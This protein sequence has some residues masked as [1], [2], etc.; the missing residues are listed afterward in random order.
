MKSPR[1]SRFRSFPQS[2]R[3]R[4]AVP[5][6]LAVAFPLFSPAQDDREKSSPHDFQK[7][8][9]RGAELLPPNVA[10]PGDV[11]M[12]PRSLEFPDEFRTID[13]TGNNKT[14]PEWGAA[15]I[16]FIRKTPVAYEDGVSEPS[17]SDRPNPREIS[18]AV[19]AQD[20]L[21]FNRLR[22]SDYLWQW[23]QFL[24]HDITLTPTTEPIEVFNIPVPAGDPYFDPQNTGAVEITMDRSFWDDHGGI[25]EQVN[26]ITAFIDASN[27][28][29][30]DQERADELRKLDGTGRLRTSR[31]NLLP[32]NVN[33]FPNAPTDRDPSFFLAG[34]FR[35]NEQA[36]LLAMHTLFVRE[37]NYWARVVARSNS[38]LDGDQIYEIARAIVG[39]EMQIIT[40]REFLP[41]LLGRD[42]I[43]PYRGYRPDVDPGIANVFAT[44]NYR[45]GHSMLSSQLLRLDERNREVDDGHLDLASAFFNPEVVSGPDGI[46]PLIRGLAMQPAQEIDTML[47]DDVR[48]FLFGP[49]GAGGF[50]LASLNIQRGRD[51]GLPTYNE[52]REAYGMRPARRFSDI[53][54]DRKVQ[55]RLEEAYDDVELVDAWIGALAESHR[56]G[57]LVGE[58]NYRVLR[59]QFLRLRDGDRFWYENH[60]DPRLQ[61]LLETQTLAKIIQRNVDVG[62]RFPD[63]PW[64][65][66]A[67]RE[68]IVRRAGHGPDVRGGFRGDRPPRRR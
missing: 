58:T 14:H 10:R 61:H 33:A 9:R 54:P 51:H 25:R 22:V 34:D 46:A 38:A 5:T 13:G 16:P 62:S 43:P 15:D 40:Y 8:E 60:L 26:E 28:Y 6:L 42:A 59:D 47:V 21:L 4:L 17:G 24:D 45:F 68:V 56:R 32:L 36:G 2:F 49:P 12:G 18:N 52:V 65:V 53:N 3:L 66:E 55:E 1:I 30:S 64:R 37:H 27:V 7:R 63:N 11:R 20:D 39:A 57:A 29:G 41:L 19:C 67:G 48:N 23:G 44:A 35:A 31:G 50:D